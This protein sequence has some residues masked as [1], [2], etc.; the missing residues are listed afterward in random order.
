MQLGYPVN[1]TKVLLQHAW[2]DMQEM[3]PAAAR[4]YYRARFAEWDG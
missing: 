2:E 3:S 1:L 4:A